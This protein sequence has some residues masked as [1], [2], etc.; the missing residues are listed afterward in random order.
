MGMLNTT[1]KIR[2]TVSAES[3]GRGWK[4]SNAAAKAFAE[5]LTHWWMSKGCNDVRVQVGGNGW[6]VQAYNASA[7]VQRSLEIQMDDAYAAWVCS[8]NADEFVND[9]LDH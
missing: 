2:A 5:F 3:M 1:I 7:A 4:D 8:G 6:C 9:C